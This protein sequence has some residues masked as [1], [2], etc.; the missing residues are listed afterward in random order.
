MEF[1]YLYWTQVEIF[2]QVSSCVILHTVAFDGSHSF[3]V[4][5]VPFKSCRLQQECCYCVVV[6][7]SRKCIG[8]IFKLGGHKKK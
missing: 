8:R 4:V 1:L 3:F 7:S 5:S 2:Q 6:G